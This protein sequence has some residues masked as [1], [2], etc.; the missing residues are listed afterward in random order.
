MALDVFLKKEDLSEFGSLRVMKQSFP[1]AVAIAAY[2]LLGRVDKILLGAFHD[3]E[4]VS[5]YHASWVVLLTGFI[6]PNVLRQSISPLLAQ[7]D[8]ASGIRDNIAG[9]RVIS[10]PLISIGIPGS[11]IISEIL[12]GII[13]PEEYFIERGFPE[14]VG[15]NLFTLLLPA[16]VW[17]MLSSGTLES[18]K[19]HPNSW[20]LAFVIGSSIFI[21]FSVGIALV[22][23]NSIFGVA[24]ATIIAQFSIFALS[25]IVQIRNKAAYTNTVLV[26][27]ITGILA[28]IALISMAIGEENI[29]QYSMLLLYAVLIT[30]SFYQLFSSPGLLNLSSRT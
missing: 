25:S 12:L 29:M 18:L 21:N 9:C 22:R 6:V 24:I 4:I 16:W 26:D 23:E 28:T 5:L 11:I 17:A 10:Y 30:T 20:I 13:F 8:S 15:V 2:P 3:Y 19:Y 14:L 7:A 27:L 1:F